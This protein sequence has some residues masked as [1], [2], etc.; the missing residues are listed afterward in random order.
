[1]RIADAYSRRDALG[2]DQGE[3][4]GYE[5]AAHVQRQQQRARWTLKLL[6]RH[7]CRPLED[8]L[9]V[10]CGRGDGLVDFV[11]WGAEPR[12]LAGIDLR[13]DVIGAARRRVTEADLRVGCGSELPFDDATFQV[14]QLSTVLSSVLE[15]E[16]RRAMVREA[17]RVTRP[18]GGLLIY[19]TRRANPRNPDVAPVR[20]AEVTEWFPDVRPEI[21]TL[22]FLPHRARR[23]PPAF[24]EWG[25][26]V[27]A[28]VPFW[29][30]HLLA[31]IGRPTRT[32]RVRP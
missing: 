24:L 29:R 8:V 16:L 32:T 9:D 19:D 30:T 6:D 11:R 2:V 1:M 14:V 21:R 28:T 7:R 17:W 15:P 26:T 27:L 10:G 3:Y 5:D 4:F 23:M 12:R 13:A 22:T 31:W 20:A 25:Y 18:G